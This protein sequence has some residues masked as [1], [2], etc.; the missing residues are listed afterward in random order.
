MVD[1]L[2]LQVGDLGGERRGRVALG[3]E[4]EVAAE[5][6]HQPLRVGL[7]VDREAGL[8]AE[9]GVLGAQDAHARGVERRHPHRLGARPD[10]G[11]DPLLHLAGGLVGERDREDLRRA[12]PCGRP[13]GRRS[14][15]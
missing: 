13:A 2:V 7:V 8:E 11:G 4:V 3:V 12:A 6:R 10:Q 14:G 1:Q 15:G 9:R 5:Q